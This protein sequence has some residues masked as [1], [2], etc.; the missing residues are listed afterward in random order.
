ML[1]NN[2]EPLANTFMSC[3]IRCLQN[4]FD[5]FTIG[6]LICIEYTELSIDLIR[7]AR[8]DFDDFTAGARSDQCPFGK[9]TILYASPNILNASHHI[10]VLRRNKLRNGGGSIQI[11]S[12]IKGAAIAQSIRQPKGNGVLPVGK[13]RN[14]DG[15]CTVRLQFS[16]AKRI[17]IYGVFDSSQ[18]AIK[19]FCSL[20]EK[21]HGLRIR[22][23][24][25]IQTRSGKYGDTSV[26]FDGYARSDTNISRHVNTPD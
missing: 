9:S 26:N 16:S 11:E 17:V 24:R 20:P 5:C 1:C 23:A 10:A 3:S 19:I 21:L 4:N 14:I 22:P 2:A 18:T 13:R 7:I 8:R 15:L 12:M 25:R 6:E